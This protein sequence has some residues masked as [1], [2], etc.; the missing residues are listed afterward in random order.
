MEVLYGRQPVREMLRAGRRR[1]D[2]L[3]LA[4]ETKRSQEL[5]EIEQLAAAARIPVQRVSRRAIGQLA[6]PG[7]H[8]GVA[9][10]VNGFP[11]VHEK[12]LP[13][14]IERISNPIL[15]FL[16]HLEDPQNV[17]SL[18]RTAEATGVDAVVLPADRAAGVTPAV[19]RA[20]AGAS[21]HLRVVRV[22]NLARCM[23]LAAGHGIR[24]VGLEAAPGAQPIR[25]I[26]LDRGVG[27]VVGSEGRGLRRMVRETCD[28]LGCLPR[29][30]RVGSLNAA[31]AGAMALYEAARQREA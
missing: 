3:L 19:V 28:L 23:R 4:T 31:V 11:Y 10:R 6:G 9:A 16:D 13:R 22:T 27:L 14:I 15:L 12:E 2:A 29:R 30:G 26:D 17:G 25:E 21:E 7:N 5:A 1:V 18:L 8:Q 20:S 24:L